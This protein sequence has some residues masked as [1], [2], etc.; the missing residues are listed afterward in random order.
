LSLDHHPE[1]LPF[2]VDVLLSI[3]SVGLLVV[4]AAAGLLQIVRVLRS[5][6]RKKQRLQRWKIQKETDAQ[7]LRASMRQ[8]FEFR[9]SAMQSAMPAA[10]FVQPQKRTA[11][12]EAD[13]YAE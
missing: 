10:E 11:L 9:Q 7:F 6:V 8:E 13:P 3:A 2:L 1:G 12:E 5:F 4:F